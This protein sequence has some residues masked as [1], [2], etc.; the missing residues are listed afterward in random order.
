MPG[1]TTTDVTVPLNPVPGA[2][3]TAPVNGFT[4]AGGEDCGGL[5]R[6]VE[7][8]PMKIYTYALIFRTHIDVHS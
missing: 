8:P 2:P 4:N 7:T 6:S 5:K 1:V 3:R